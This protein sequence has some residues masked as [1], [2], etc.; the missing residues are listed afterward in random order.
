MFGIE[1]NIVFNDLATDSNY[2]LYVYLS[3]FKFMLYTG[4][5][6]LCTYMLAGSISKSFELFIF[7]FKSYIQQID[8]CTGLE[9]YVNNLVF[10]IKLNILLR[11]P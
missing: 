11:F 3:I 5:T 7:F 8:N 9:Y 10:Q 4:P 6:F 1:T 2:A